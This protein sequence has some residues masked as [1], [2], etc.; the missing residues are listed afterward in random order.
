M[1]WGQPKQ[2]LQRRV[3]K[4]TVPPGQPQ[5]GRDEGTTTT[6][7]DHQ[8]ISSL[9]NKSGAHCALRLGE[10]LRQHDLITDAQLQEALHI[11]QTRKTYTPLGHILV[12]QKTLTPAQLTY[13]LAKYHTQLQLSDVLIKTRLITENQLQT[14]L[15][16]QKRLGV[17]LGAA[18]LKLNYISEEALKQAICLQLNIPFVELDLMSLDRSLAKLLNKNYAQRHHVVPI[19]RIGTILTV[20]L[21]DPTDT[22]VLSDLQ[23]STDCSINVVPSTHAAIRQA[24]KES[25]ISLRRRQKT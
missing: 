22:E 13:Y 1:Q 20:V 5:A 2:S 6:A 12:E 23:A 18:L 17:S 24:L 25:T 21:E 11:Q 3:T 19:S 9:T 15:E 16:H 7:E 14:A 10:I 4:Q 8:N